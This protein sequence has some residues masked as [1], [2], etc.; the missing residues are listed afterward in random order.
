MSRVLNI[1]FVNVGDIHHHGVWFRE[2]D[3]ETDLV[4]IRKSDHPEALGLTEYFPG[5]GISISQLR[6]AVPAA[7]LVLVP[8]NKD[9][10]PENWNA[11]FKWAMLEPG[12]GGL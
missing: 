7:L 4:E 3:P 6:A 8:H 2:S 5:K 9:E 12:Q 1:V 10:D 11:H